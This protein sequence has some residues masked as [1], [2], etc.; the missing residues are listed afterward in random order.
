V[1]EEA[2]VP[3]AWAQKIMAVMAHPD[4]PDF[5]CGGTFAKWAAEGK[6][7]IYVLFTRGDK[8]TS[9]PDMTPDRL[10]IIREQEERAAAK[11]LGVKDVIF[12]GHP[13]G[14][15]EDTAEGRGQVV[16]L[17]REFRPD[18]LVTMDPFRRYT[19]HRDHRHAAIMAMDAVFPYARDRLSYPEHEKMGLEPHKVGEI[20]ISGPEE[21]EFFID[22]R[23][24]F[25][26]KVDALM[27]H[28]SQVGEDRA[29]FAERLQA[30]SRRFN[31]NLPEGYEPG[32]F[33]AFR[34]ISYRQ[35]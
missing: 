20:F 21:P 29:G 5:S 25:E 31:T 3:G 7:I 13:D 34:K 35:R 27:C 23:D 4:D 12:L 24:T 30:M 1:A 18:I 2:E 32:K 9:D 10:Q 16:K 11:V 6:E 33:E 22:I 17:I 26:T 19:Q 15:V 14:G 28:C 8:G